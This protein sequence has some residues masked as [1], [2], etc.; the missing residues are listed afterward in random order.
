LA[1][2]Y[3][4][5][6]LVIAKTVAIRSAI[7]DVASCRVQCGAAL[8]A[9]NPIS[10]QSPC[11]YVC[12]LSSEYQWNATLGHSSRGDLYNFS[13]IAHLLPPLF[14]DLES[15]SGTGAPP[16]DLA[17]QLNVSMLLDVRDSKR[18]LAITTWPDGEVSVPTMLLGAKFSLIDHHGDETKLAYVDRG[19]STIGVGPFVTS[20]L[21][22]ATSTPAYAAVCRPVPVCAT[23]SG[24]VLI[25]EL[26]R[27]INT[28][29]VQFLVMH[30]DPVT[31]DCTLKR[32][33]LAVAVVLLA[34]AAVGEVILMAIGVK[35]QV[36]AEQLL[37]PN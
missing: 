4:I 37:P 30:A 23:D 35:I 28:A 21:L 26:N 14:V 13:T 24:E 10:M 22:T 1:D 32:E 19:T 9:R 18:V 31:G 25:P 27:C 3:A 2:I 16:N 6:P 34:V 33:L 29:C 8:D 11:E 5:V 7:V 15:Q 17:L 12:E 20:T 36:M